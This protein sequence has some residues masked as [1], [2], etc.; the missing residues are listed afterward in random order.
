MTVRYA[1]W[2]LLWLLALPSAVAQEQPA[3]FTPTSPTS[4]D[5]VRATFAIPGTCFPVVTKTTITGSTIRENLEFSCFFGPPPFDRPYDVTLG[6]LPAGTYTF[7][8][9]YDFR[10]G[11]APIRRSTQPL[12]VTEAPEIPVL[13]GAALALMAAVFVVIAVA[14]AGRVSG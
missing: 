8:V 9:F 2:I 3:V 7:E 12:V 11:F 5:V 13:S 4:R 14:A 1:I 10:D 6:R